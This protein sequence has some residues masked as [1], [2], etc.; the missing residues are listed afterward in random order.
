MDF[1][2]YENKLEYPTRPKK[3]ILGKDHTSKDLDDYKKALQKYEEDMISCKVKEKAYDEEYRRLYFLFKKD[4]LNDV[5]LI[6][7]PKAEKVFSLA[8]EK[9]HSGGL[10]D[11]YCELGELADLLIGE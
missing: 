4:A 8:W 1:E 9:G 10:N 5:G 7:H 2:K 11:V 3:P 6:D